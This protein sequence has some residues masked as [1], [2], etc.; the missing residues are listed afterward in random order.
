MPTGPVLVIFHFVNIPLPYIPLHYPSSVNILD[1]HNIA[2]I[3]NEKKKHKSLLVGPTWSVPRNL[4][5]P[6]SG[7]SSK[8][9]SNCRLNFQDLWLRDAL[10]IQVLL[11]NHVQKG[12][13]KNFTD[14]RWVR[15]GSGSCNLK[16]S[17]IWKR[18]YHF[19]TA[20]NTNFYRKINVQLNIHSASVQCFESA[21]PHNKLCKGT[22]VTLRFCTKQ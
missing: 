22:V 17:Y 13:R 19:F 10:Q 20:E 1:F 16:T 8:H 7:A 21:A 11:L 2:Q 14:H 6:S 12:Y 15:Q 5:I 9:L 3:W 18:D 4:L